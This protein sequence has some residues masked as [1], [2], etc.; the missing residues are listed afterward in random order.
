MML[1]LHLLMMPIQI[2]TIM[3]LLIEFAVAQYVAQQQTTAL[4]M[5]NLTFF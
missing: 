5:S 4:H 2:Y 1:S 3:L